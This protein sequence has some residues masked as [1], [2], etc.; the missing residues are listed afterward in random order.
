VAT[1]TPAQRKAKAKARRAKAA[2][3]AGRMGRAAGGRVGSIRDRVLPPEFGCCGQVFRSEA[4]LNAHLATHGITPSGRNGAAPRGA[5]V[6]GK[7]RQQAPKPVR[8]GGGSGAGP[9]NEFVRSARGLANLDPA[10]AED[11]DVLFT[12]VKRAFAQASDAVE[13]F[14][15]RLDIEYQLD[16]RVVRNVR[17]AA[18]ALG[19]SAAEAFLDARKQ[20]RSCYPGLCEV[21]DAGVRMPAAGFLS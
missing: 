15:D 10:D 20:L 5:K 8:R 11:L 7:P 17:E 21:R 4:A 19:E 3:V 18:D 12:Q 6:N 1:I 16:R 9:L 2:K 13:D 14:A